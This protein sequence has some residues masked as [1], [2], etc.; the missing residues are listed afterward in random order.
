[1]ARPGV[2]EGVSEREGGGQS[3]QVLCLIMPLVTELPAPHK[4]LDKPLLS[5]FLCLLI[6][7]LLLILS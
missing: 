3:S 7:V 5:F 6:S 1:M 4:H 2:G